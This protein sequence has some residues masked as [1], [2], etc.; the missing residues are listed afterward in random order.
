MSFKTK[1]PES[2]LFY[3][4]FMNVGQRKNRENT[5]DTIIFLSYNL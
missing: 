5:V 1:V 2:P 3:S 4:S